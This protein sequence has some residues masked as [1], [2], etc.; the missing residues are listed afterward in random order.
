MKRKAVEH[1]GEEKRVKFDDERNTK[2][3]P[4]I[5]EDQPPKWLKGEIS[6]IKKRKHK[7]KLPQK[8]IEQLGTVVSNPFSDSDDDEVIDK[9]DTPAYT[10]MLLNLELLEPHE[11]IE[12]PVVVLVRGYR[13]ALTSSIRMGKYKTRRPWNDIE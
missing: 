1:G 11:L 5:V 9:K 6:K 13:Q 2:Q 10:N 12:E 4:K 8:E 3:E 7:L